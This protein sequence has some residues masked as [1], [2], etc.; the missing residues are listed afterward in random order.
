MCQ[1]QGPGAQ[2]AADCRAERHQRSA[3]ALELRNKFPFPLSTLGSTYGSGAAGA[4]C[5]TIRGPSLL[6]R[7]SK[8]RCALHFKRKGGYEREIYKEISVVCVVSLTNA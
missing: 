4:D 6:S 1:R 8:S 3:V 7:R 2:K 5:G